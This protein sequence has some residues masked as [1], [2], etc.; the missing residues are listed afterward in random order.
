MDNSEDSYS[1]VIEIDEGRR[2]LEI[3]RVY[4]DGRRQLFTSADLPKKAFSEDKQGFR[5]FAKVLGENVLVDSPVAR[6]L[7]GI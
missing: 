3:F 5:D 2:V 4:P 6:R 1:H 7:L